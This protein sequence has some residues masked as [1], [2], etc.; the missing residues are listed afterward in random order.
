MSA[1]LQALSPERSKLGSEASEF[2][3]L[4]HIPGEMS[5]VQRPMNC[6]IFAW[7]QPF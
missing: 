5:L 2:A 6:L 7:F 3:G 1:A 4:L